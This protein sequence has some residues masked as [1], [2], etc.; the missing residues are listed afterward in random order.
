MYL[1][2]IPIGL[3]VLPIIIGLFVFKG[4]LGKDW[5]IKEGSVSIK[6]STRKLLDEIFI[7][8]I[9]QNNESVKVVTGEG[10]YNIFTE[11]VVSALEETKKPSE[12]VVGPIVSVTEDRVSYLIEAAARKKIRLYRAK[13]R[14]KDHYR[15]GK[16]HLYI[17]QH[18]EPMAAERYFT[19]VDNVP[20]EIAQF[21]E[22]FN[23][24][25]SEAEFS[26]D[27]KRDFLFLTKEDLRKIP[28]DEEDFS[29]MD[30]FKQ[31]LV[32][33]GIS[34]YYGASS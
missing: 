22:R 33:N 16:S 14:P 7:R 8:C 9:G 2:V 3:L 23:K 31:Y 6:K 26:M 5:H 13:R 21:Q 10:S 15:V 28:Y 17:E 20:R 4:L 32:S 18:H 19:E 25:K 11:N 29:D 12:V 1:A 24:L 34:F 30:G 27:P